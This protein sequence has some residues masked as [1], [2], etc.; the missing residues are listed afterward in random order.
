[1][2][3]YQTVYG[4]LFASFVALVATLLEK[5]GL[6]LSLMVLALII[7]MFLSQFV[8]ANHEAGLNF[9]VKTLLR[10]AV[11][12]LG[13]RIAFSDII[14]LGLSSILF[15]VFAMVATLF[16]SF[17]LSHFLRLSHGLATMNGAANAI[18]GASAV[19]A[20]SSVVPDYKEK[21]C[22]IAYLVIMANLTSTIAMIGYPFISSAFKLTEANT[23]FLL[24]ATIH[25]M[26]QVVSAGYAISD[27]V[28][29]SSIIVKLFRVSLLLPIV[30]SLGFYLNKGKSDASVPFPLFAA[31]FIALCLLNS[32]LQGTQPF[33]MIKPYLITL[34]N[35]LMLIAISALGLQ[36]N[37]ASLKTSGWKVFLLFITTSLFLLF[38]FLAYFMILQ[39]IT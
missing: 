8:K 14:Q 29:N 13:I 31:G 11:G 7:G 3:H 17:I 22:D 39:S 9:C 15:I 20:T 21:L 26:A 19:L 37:I 24:G 27:T 32:L 28:G 1:M 30:L 2:L 10:F 5:L 12:L 6:K 38:I 25:D 34:S 4:F 35:F 18:C 36:T 33:D 23:G 16:F